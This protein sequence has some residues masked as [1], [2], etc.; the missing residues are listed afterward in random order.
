[1]SNKI[2]LSVKN[3]KVNYVTSEGVV[4]AVDNVSF[5][6]YEGETLGLVG[7][8]G[9]GKSTLLLS[10]LRLLPE[11]AIIK[12]EIIFEGKN[13]LEKSEDE[14]REIRGKKI[15]M[16]FQDPA[17][18]WNPVLSIGEQIAE[19]IIFHL[20]QELIEEALRNKGYVSDLLKSGS[21]KISKKEIKKLAID[22]CTELLKFVGLP[23]PADIVKRYPHELS[24]GM[25]QRA[26]I[27]VAL[28]CKPILILADEPTTA[29]DVTIQ[30]Q[31]LELL[32]RLKKE[33]GF[34]MILVTH[35]LGVVAE[36][37]T[38][39]AVMYAGKIIEVAGVRELFR[40]PMHPYT[41]GLLGAV[42]KLHEDV[43]ELALIPGSIPSPINPPSGCR[44]HPRC[45]Y[46]MDIC[47]KEEP[48]LIEVKKDHLVACHLLT[49][50]GRT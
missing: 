41:Q 15:A 24:G 25:K 23:D 16:V 5:D 6:L 19:A 12:G 33:Y 22:R 35:D 45:M 40:N 32:D 20:E 14:I 48:P 27:A 49:S 29:L 9:C 39:V 26:M 47:K 3:L 11:N 36:I 18:Y 17:M 10:I 7:E 50:G 2:V 21:P 43:I 38:R 42:P 13:L 46:V 30:A 28:A 1:M 8:S 4:K 44:F 34:S 37:C 31:I